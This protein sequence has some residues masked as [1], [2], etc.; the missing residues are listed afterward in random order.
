M[1]L[2][3]LEDFMALVEEKNFSRAAERRHVSQPAF[4]RRIQALEAWIGTPLLVRSSRNVALTPAGEL[5]KG[6]SESILREVAGARRDAL[7]VSGRG[8]RSLSIAATHAL[9]FTFFPHWISRHARLEETGAVNLI[10]DSMEACE[11]LMLRGGASFLL[12]HHHPAAETK[13]SARLFESMTVGEDALVPVCAPDRRGRA[14]WSLA[15][16]NRG[17]IPYLSY[18]RPSGLGRILEADWREKGVR[19]DLE[20]VVTSRLAATLLELAREGRGLAWLPRSLVERELK[21]GGLLEAGCTDQEALLKIALFRP[22]ARLDAAAE[23]F[24]A[25][26]RSRT[27]ASPPA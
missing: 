25:G 22:H 15:R 14:R 9:S 12:C 27:P 4:S 3:W 6:R 10:S 17:P 11:A 1:E 24:W 26:L 23:A 13:L 16:G 21:A 5:L 2:G 7:E 18:D 8:R 19:Y 20:P